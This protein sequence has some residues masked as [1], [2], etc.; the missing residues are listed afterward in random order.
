M[1]PGCPLDQDCSLLGSYAVK[2]RKIS[3]STCSDPLIDNAATCWTNEGSLNELTLT[4]HPTF[5]RAAGT[6]NKQSFTVSQWEPGQFYYAAVVVFTSEVIE[7]S[8]NAIELLSNYFW[9]RNEAISKCPDPYFKIDTSCTASSFDYEVKLD[10]ISTPL[11]CNIVEA[12][13]P[14][15]TGTYPCPLFC[16]V[17]GTDTM[18]PNAG[19]MAC[20]DT[21]VT[22][23][24]YLD[25]SDPAL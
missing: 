2:V 9:M 16:S 18:C 12:I 15:Y 17:L 14:A 24:S 3:T 8:G 19:T 11:D 20:H 10:N 13:D 25:I 1:T 22:P 6:L 5:T 7:T 4:N 21:S 23:I